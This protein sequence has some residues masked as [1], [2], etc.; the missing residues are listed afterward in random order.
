VFH[1]GT[2]Y[3]IGN[4]E[5]CGTFV[6]GV[7]AYVGRGE[8]SGDCQAGGA[9]RGGAGQGSGWAAESSCGTLGHR[10]AMA[11]DRTADAKAGHEVGE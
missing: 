9:E 2:G 3:F 7:L 11:K 5:G 8:G 6:G 4:P 1:L 10:K